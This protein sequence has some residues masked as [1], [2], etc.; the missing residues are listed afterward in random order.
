MDKSEAARLDGVLVQIHGFRPMV[1]QLSNQV[2][3]VQRQQEQT[4]RR[5]ARLDAEREAHHIALAEIRQHTNDLQQMLDDVEDRHHQV[6]APQIRRLDDT[7]ERL[8]Q[9][10]D[11][12]KTA[13]A[14]G[15]TALRTLSA[16]FHSSAGAF[17]NQIQQQYHHLEH[18]LEEKAPRLETEARIEDL[19]RQMASKVAD[20]AHKA[21]SSGVKDLQVRCEKLKEHVELSTR[22]LDWFARRGEAYEH[23]LELVETQLGRLALA[24]HPRRREPFGERV[25]F[26]RSP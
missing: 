15:D 7:T 6:V 21:L 23:N 5:V 3:S 24:S 26:P 10:L 19:S 14:T 22:F 8:H 20:T 16:K 13:A 11:E 25:R 17:A 18:V 9:A 4:E 2:K 1:S 12:A